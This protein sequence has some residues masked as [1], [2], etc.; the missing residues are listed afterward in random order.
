MIK[1]RDSIEIS[2]P[3]SKVFAFVSDVSNIPRWQAEVVQSA[4]V[5]PGP[6][7]V[8]TRFDEVV[9]VGPWRVTT[10][11]V[12]TEYEPDRLMAFKAESSP[13]QFEGKIGLEA[14]KDKTRVTLDGTAS[15][16]G[17][18]RLMQVALARDLQKGAEHELQTL[19]EILETR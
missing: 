7:K 19:K 9:K 1:V 8:G 4:I 11:C 14:S 3:Q 12:V 5:T 15:P 10:H 6:I 18:Y 13:L 16:R 2:S 17:F